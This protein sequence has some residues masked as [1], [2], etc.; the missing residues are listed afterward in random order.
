MESINVKI[1]D[2]ITK[3]E[4]VDDG[5]GPST[6]EPTVEVEVLDVEVE[7][8]TPEKESTPLNSRVETRI[9]SRTA[10][11]LTPSKV[12]PPIS[13]NDE[14]STSKKPSS[15]VIKNHPGSN[16]IGSLDEGLCLRKRNYSIY[17]TIA[18]VQSS[19]D[20]SILVEELGEHT[21]LESMGIIE[22]SDDKEDEGTVG[23]QETYNSFLEKTSEYAKV[24]KATIKKMKRA[25][26]DYRSLLVQYKETKCEMEMLNGELTEAYSKIKFLE[27]EVV[28]A[29]AKVERVSSKKL[30]E[31]L[32]HQKPFSD[33]S[34]L[35]Y[36]GESS[37]AINI[38][39]EMKF[40][41][42]KEPVVETSV[43]EKVNWK[44]SG[45]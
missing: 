45:M 17:M 36:T 31:V 6:K 37:L 20:L 15:R 22:E 13:R 24:A 19:N 35:G 9:M 16:I 18:L 4:L 32:A 21:E 26:E 1:V 43:V 12:H 41:K 30:D 23:L 5:E 38:S 10:S 14:V 39:K 40:V 27:L 33:R 28:Q 2:A 44:R 3:V 8:Y 25:E 7:E 42:A 11:P 29:N 34:G